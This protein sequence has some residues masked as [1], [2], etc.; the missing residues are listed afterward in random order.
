M[1]LQLQRQGQ[2]KKE[3]V[4]LLEHMD[5]MPQR[6]T[7]RLI[8]ILECCNSAQTPVSLCERRFVCCELTDCGSTITYQRICF[9]IESELVLEALR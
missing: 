2:P 6:L 7:P 1:E 9:T 3:V 4:N 5:S 8:N